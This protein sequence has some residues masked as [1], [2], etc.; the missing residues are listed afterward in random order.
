MND[1]PVYEK[2]VVEF[3]AVANEYCK[4]LEL[5]EFESLSSFVDKLHKMVP[6]LYLKA[7]VLPGLDSTYEELN[8][9]FVEENDYNALFNKLIDK[10]GDHDFYEEIYDPLRQEND[11]LINLLVSEGLAD[12]YQDIKNFLLLY[13]V[14]TYE[15][16]YEAIWEIKQSFE[17]SWG[18][19]LVNL[20][21]VFHDLR[22]SG[23]DL[24][25]THDS[26]DKTDQ[27]V[28]ENNIDIF[29]QKQQDYKNGEHL[30][31]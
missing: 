13:E 4:L 2:N 26:E 3:V 6:L 25:K 27:L 21:R 19:K 10:F 1:N 24:D 28:N 17:L 16:M 11:E 15:V 20:Q 31:L 23:K 5:E 9:T 14:S 18:Q 30:G 8:E 29:K 22:Y 12:I 7:T